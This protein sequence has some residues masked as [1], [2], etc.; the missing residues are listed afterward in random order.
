MKGAGWNECETC[1]S[2]FMQ[3]AMACEYRDKKVERKK[4]QRMKERRTHNFTPKK[5]YVTN[6]YYCY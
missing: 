1:K 3:H 6:Y 4:K 5:I 2:G